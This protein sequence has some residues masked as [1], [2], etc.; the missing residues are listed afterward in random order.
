M[1]LQIVDITQEAEIVDLDR[2][3]ENLSKYENWCEMVGER[4]AWVA[5][6]KK[7]RLQGTEC[8]QNGS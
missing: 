3:L 2:A 1:D 5:H 8:K 4:I 6:K 7:H